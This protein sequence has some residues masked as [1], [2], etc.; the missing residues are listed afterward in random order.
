MLS[1][2]LNFIIYVTFG[3]YKIRG[4]RENKKMRRE[5]EN[6]LFP[7]YVILTYF[8]YFSFFVSRLSNLKIKIKFYYML[9]S[10]MF[11]S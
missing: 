10:F 7:L 2:Y 5:S 11:F 8:L 6:K 1:E 4:K 9:F 3:F